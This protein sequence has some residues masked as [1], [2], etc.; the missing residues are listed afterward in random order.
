MNHGYIVVQIYIEQKKI[1]KTY[2]SG[3]FQTHS[4]GVHARV[5]RMHV[6]WITRQT[7]TRGVHASVKR[8]H[9]VCIHA[10]N[11]YTWCACTRRT[12]ARVKRMHV[13][14]NACTWRQT[15]ARGVKRMHVASNACTWRQTHARLKRTSQTH[16]CGEH[17]RVKRMHVACM[18]ESNACMW[19]ACTSQTHA[20]GVHARV[21]RMRVACMHGSNIFKLKLG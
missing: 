20:C 6:L 18:R 11:A 2:K 14:S 1:F 19:R 13:A 9:V 4:W 12:H 16:A 3:K 17:T 10:S 15:H 5:K 7:H 21:K 8:I